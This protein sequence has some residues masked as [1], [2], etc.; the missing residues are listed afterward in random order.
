MAS[1]SPRSLDPSRIYYGTD[2]RA[3]GLLFG[4]ALAMVWPSRRLTT[5]ITRAAR[6]NLDIMGCGGLP[7][8]AIM[9]W[10]TGEFSQFLYRGGFVVLSLATVM[11]LMPLAHPACKLGNLVGCQR[12]R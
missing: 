8:I 10:R 6:K 12:R 11:V 7:I 4:A 1:L 9:I 3:A 2:T 5:K